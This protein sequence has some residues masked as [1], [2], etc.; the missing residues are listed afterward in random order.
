MPEPLDRRT[1]TL[2]LVRDGQHHT[3]IVEGGVRRAR[4]SVWIATANLKD[5]HVEARP[6][7]RSRAQGRFTSLFDELGEAAR[8]GVE[9]R[10]LCSGAPSRPLSERIRKLGRPTVGLRRCP[11]SHL[12]MIA[13]DG[14]L[15]YL[16]SAN[17]TGAGLGAKGEHR[18]NFEAGIVTDDDW[19]LDQMQATFDD[20]WQGRRCAGC[21]LGRECPTPLA[22]PALKVRQARRAATA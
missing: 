14:L 21:Q 7:T 1:V 4:A 10:I 22:G 11:R 12:K 6:G 8:R 15:L 16:G 20:I 17:F 19:L 18:R 9:V 3:E 5:L 2:G 13:V